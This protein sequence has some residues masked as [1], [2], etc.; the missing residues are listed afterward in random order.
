[1]SII[2]MIFFCWC[3][4]SWIQTRWHHRQ[5][6]SYGKNVAILETFLFTYQGPFYKLKWSE[7]NNDY[8]KQHFP[9]LKTI[10]LAERNLKAYTLLVGTRWLAWH[11]SLV[12]TPK[13]NYSPCDLLVNMML[14]VNCP[15]LRW[16]SYVF[17]L[18]ILLCVRLNMSKLCTKW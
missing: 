13:F 2:V 9:N 3:S 15:V 5:L 18:G 12:R 17:Y 16:S 14:W 8:L 6:D 10:V 7:I 4:T 11:C 1:M